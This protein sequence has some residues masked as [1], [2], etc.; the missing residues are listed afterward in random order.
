MD[1]FG[2]GCVTFEDIEAG[3]NACNHADVLSGAKSEGEALTAFMS[4]WETRKR[5]GVVSLE[6]FE[7]YFLDLSSTVASDDEFV[8]LVRNT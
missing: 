3:F 1:R 8:T 7:S 6:E 5:T 4:E 2:R